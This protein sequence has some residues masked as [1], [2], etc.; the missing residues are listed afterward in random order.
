MAFAGSR[1]HIGGPRDWNYGKFDDAETPEYIIARSRYCSAAALMIPK[2]LF[3][4][5]GGFEFPLR[6]RLLRGHRPGVQSSKSG[7]KVYIN[8]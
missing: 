7:Y 5:M 4:S 8:R 2:S 3:A 1:R 6:A